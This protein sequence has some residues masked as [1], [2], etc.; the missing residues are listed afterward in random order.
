M[1]IAKNI[2][3]YVHIKKRNEVKILHN[4]MREH[5]NNIKILRINIT[6]ISIYKLLNKK[7][8]I[9]VQR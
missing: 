8:V 9:L 2:E 5:N 3:L 7:K 4:T 1:G 6:I